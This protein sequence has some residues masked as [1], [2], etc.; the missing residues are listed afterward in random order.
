VYIFFSKIYYKTYYVVAHSLENI[1]YSLLPIAILPNGCI[2]HSNSQESEGL[3]RTSYV[4]KR[5]VYLWTNKANG[6]Q[7]I[8][9]A[10]DISS[11]L[12]N[13][14]S[15]SYIKF[16]STRGSAI[17]AA[18]LKHGLSGFSLQIIVLGDSPS[19]ASISVNSDHILLE[20]YYLDR[21]IL[22]YNIRRIALGPAPALNN[23]AGNQHANLQEGKKGP[24]SYAWN[25]K[26]SMEQKFLWSL[27]RSTAIFVYHSSTLKFNCIVYG[28]E[29]LA[30]LLGVH[31]N[32]ARRVANSG[33]V[34]ANKYI[35]SLTDLDKVKLQTIK[36]KVKSNSTKIKVVH[37]Y[38][39]N[40]RVLLKTFSSV[41]AF[42]RFSKQSGFN[43]RLF[44]TTDQLWLGEYYLSYDL[45]LGADNT[46]TSVKEF[47][48]KF[49]SRNTSIPVYTYSSD[50]LTFIKRYSSLREAVKAL[51]G[52][53]NTNTSSLEL[54]INHKKLY[55]G[56]RVSYHPLFDH[57]Q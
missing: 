24:E 12:S 16:Q 51:D 31:T 9:S 27:T 5:G 11:R 18:I 49:K 36:V 50:G 40:K 44:C 23:K 6:N 46:L 13:Y 43:V 54:R 2:E 19:R 15:K 34:Y 22:S 53:R 21:Y 7:Y 3:V 42:M 1:S 8:G 28:Y 29:R 45:I 33:Y 39:N 35:I 10:M 20:Q 52:N 26:H 4:N 47:K 25:H 37:V 14:F 32:T 57:D 55:K 30:G 38:D 56:L 48:P 41:N 17:S